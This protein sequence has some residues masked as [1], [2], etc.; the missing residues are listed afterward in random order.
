M[1]HIPNKSGYLPWD[2][3]CRNIETLKAKHHRVTGEDHKTYTV[4]R[5][6]N[7][8][9]YVTG[10]GGLYASMKDVLIL[11]ACHQLDSCTM[12]LRPSLFNCKDISTDEEYSGVYKV[13]GM[14]GKSW[15]VIAG[16]RWLGRG[17][18]RHWF[19]KELRGPRFGTAEE[20]ME[21]I[22]KIET[23]KKLQ[24][25]KREKAKNL[26][27]PQPEKKQ[28]TFDDLVN[29][30]QEEVVAPDISMDLPA[31]RDY[32]QTLV[33]DLNA[34]IGID[35]HKYPKVKREY[36]IKIGV[37]VVDMGLRLKAQK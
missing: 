19:I 30:P 7:E 12:G 25:Q 32:L 11:I 20:V 27:P 18:S 33:V 34:A 29:R 36:C 8:W 21:E 6:K 5:N 22:K 4:Q 16:K 23:A 26:L 2:Y 14:S 28:E 13:T 10:L 9:W 35:P 1:E 31:I 24:H 3:Y 15:T 37:R 17:Q